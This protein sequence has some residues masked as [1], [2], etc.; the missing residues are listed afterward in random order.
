VVQY[1]YD[2]ITAS[3]E[4]PLVLPFEPAVVP[5]PHCQG[6]LTDAVFLSR[7]ELQAGQSAPWVFSHEAIAGSSSHSQQ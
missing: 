1:A 3:S 5:A 6:Q 4:Q 2:L 7:F